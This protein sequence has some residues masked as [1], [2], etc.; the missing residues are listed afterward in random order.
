[1]EM[2]LINQMPFPISRHPDNPVI[3]S[4][5]SNG[6]KSGGHFPEVWNFFGGFAP[7]REK[8]FTNLLSGGDP[9]IDLFTEVGLFEHLFRPMLFGQPKI[10]Q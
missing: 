3:L 7:L 2:L 9:S 4:K 6:W 10:N 1:M 5:N 8:I